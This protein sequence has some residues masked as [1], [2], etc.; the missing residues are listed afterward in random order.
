MF[1]KKL[2]RVKAGDICQI[3]KLPVA[4][5]CMPFVRVRHRDLWIVC[6]D[7]NEAR[8]NGYWFFRFLREQHPE[9]DCVYAIS[10]SSPDFKRVS[11][12][13]PTVEYGSLWHWIL[14]FASSKKI[15]SQK[16]GN[17]NAAIFYFLEVYGLLRDKRI[18]LQHGVIKDDLKW[19]Y[20][21]VTRMNRFICGTYPEW[22]YVSDLYG[23]PEGSVHYTG[24]CRFD[25]LHDATPQRMVLVMPTWR[26]WIADED[27]RLER[28]EGTREISKTN[29]FQ[30]WTD[31]IR[32]AHVEAL[33]R[34]YQVKFIF[35]PHRNMQKYLEYFPESTQYI[36][37]AGANRYGVQELM[38]NAAMMVTDYSS[39]FFDMLYM[40][41]PVAFY[42]FDLERFRLG[43]YAEGYFHYDDNPFGRSCRTKDD[44]FNE[45]ERILANN[46]VVDSEYLKAHGEYFPLYD[47]NN[48]RRVYDVVKEL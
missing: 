43:Q 5:F 41:K 6:E 22:K 37:I 16:S 11:A 13:G 40:K 32:D 34:K 8:D 3:W 26:E 20:Y 17:P 23:Y 12:L 33:A 31:F 18:F 44:I 19:L 7:R 21:D 1:I 29:Y 14:Y 38:K 42:Q 15:S 48:C 10:C 9:Q 35:F 25:G 27:E 4:L 47:Q 45:I 30:A 28:Y 36:E 39:V 46:F 24:L 2:K